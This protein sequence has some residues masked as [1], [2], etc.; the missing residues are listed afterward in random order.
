[1]MRMD[2]PIASSGNTRN[3][4]SAEAFHDV[5]VPSGSC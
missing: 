4:R 2:L 3:I 1:M 5:I